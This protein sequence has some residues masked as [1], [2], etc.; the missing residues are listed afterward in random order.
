MSR[1]AVNYARNGSKLTAVAMLLPWLYALRL[2]ATAATV[3][4]ILIIAYHVLR[5]GNP[6]QELGADHFDQYGTLARHRLL[7]RLERVGWESLDFLGTPPAT[8]G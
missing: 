3:Y 8:N 4:K 6:Y 2:T 1:A 7:R 5:D